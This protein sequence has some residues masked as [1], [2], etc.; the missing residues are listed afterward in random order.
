MAVTR[1]F[2]N[3]ALLA[4]EIIHLSA[5]K[6]RRPDGQLANGTSQTEVT[7]GVIGAGITHSPSSPPQ[8]PWPLSYVYPTTPQTP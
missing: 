5:F 7:Q 8:T 2:E 4:M 1:D 3:L 6:D